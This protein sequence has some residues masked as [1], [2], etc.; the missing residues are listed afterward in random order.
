NGYYYWPLGVPTVV[1]AAPAPGIE[2]RRAFQVQGP[3][4]EVGQIIVGVMPHII[5]Q[6]RAGANQDYGPDHSLWDM[7]CEMA[8]LDHLWKQADSPPAFLP[9][10]ELT[11]DLMEAIQRRTGYSPFPVF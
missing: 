9:L 8:V 3:D 4:G 10:Y 1:I 6:V 5:E 7:V 2:V 11:G